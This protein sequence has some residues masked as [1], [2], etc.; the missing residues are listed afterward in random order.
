MEEKV[1][2]RVLVVD[3]HLVVRQ[4]FAMFLR[5]FADLE[6]V[7]EA[8]NGEEAVKMCEEL[9]PDVILMD[10]MMP[11]MN[12]IEAIRIIRQKFPQ[13]QVIALT[14]YGDDKQLVQ[15][16]LTAGAV[17]FLFKDISVA[18]LANAIRLA[19]KGM[20]VLS[21]EA[22]RMLIFSKTQRTSQDFNLSDREMEVLALLVQGLSN[23]EIAERLTISRSTIK[24]HVSSILGKLGAN[25]RTEAVSIAHQYKLVN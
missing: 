24:F 2:I 6:M 20:P 13:T 14:S 16:A 3:D 12:G 9:K 1:V 4:G 5:A 18:E 10:M 11:V 23:R 21:P 17:S 22:T 7:G 15:N 19:Y 25:S 8:A